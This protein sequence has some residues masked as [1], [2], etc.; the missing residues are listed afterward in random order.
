MMILSKYTGKF[1]SLAKSIAHII[2]VGQMFMHALAYN[3]LSIPKL[4]LDTHQRWIHNQIP[5]STLPAYYMY[6]LCTFSNFEWLLFLMTSKTC[7]Y[8][9]I[10][11]ILGIC[12]HTIVLNY[13]RN[14]VSWAQSSLAYCNRK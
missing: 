1:S 11:Y 9:N 10:L 5:Y 2:L 8:D 6:R 3:V 14:G 7:R 13:K 12:Y 4:C